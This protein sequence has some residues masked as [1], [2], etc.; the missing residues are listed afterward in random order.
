VKKKKRYEKEMDGIK[1]M[2]IMDSIENL[3][4]IRNYTKV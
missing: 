4:R 2:E 1:K 3:G